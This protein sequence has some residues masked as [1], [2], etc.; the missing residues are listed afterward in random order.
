M[1]ELWNGLAR[2]PASLLVLDNFPEDQKV[3][4]YLPVTGPVHTLVTTRRQDLTDYP[5]LRLGLLPEEDA[6][7]LLNSG[8]R[9]FP[10]EEAKPLVERLGGL[11]LALELARG[12]LNVRSSLSVADMVAFMEEQGHI[13]S[14]QAFARE[15]RDELPSRHE[16]DVAKTF[17]LS[18]DLASESSRAVLRL[19]HDVLSRIPAHSVNRLH[20]LL[21]H[22]WKPLAISAQA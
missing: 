8:V 15:Y 1:E 7:A 9:R 10:A 4:A 16:L 5:H 17:L 13:R 11:P 18:W 14:L 21:P 2:L 22:I 6:L 20:E 12:C 3:A 19:L